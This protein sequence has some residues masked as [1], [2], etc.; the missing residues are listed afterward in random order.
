VVLSVH[1]VVDPVEVGLSVLHPQA[2]VAA[3]HQ[4]AVVEEV[5]LP[6]AEGNCRLCQQKEQ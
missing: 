6:G 1:Q 3:V 5:Q 2:Q 4:A